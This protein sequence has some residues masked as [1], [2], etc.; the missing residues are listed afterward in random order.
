[1][2]ALVTTSAVE[3]ILSVLALAVFWAA[4]L[5]LAAG[6]VG[7]LSFPAHP[8]G[9]VLLTAGL[10]GLLAMPILRLVTAIAE[11]ARARDWILLGATLAVMAILC[12]LTLRDAATMN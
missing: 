7:W 9:Q 2:G 12:A 8:S 1:M 5:C 6:L 10:T 11:A 3:R 4:F